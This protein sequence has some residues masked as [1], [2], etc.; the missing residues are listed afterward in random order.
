MLQQDPIQAIGMTKQLKK[1]MK[2]KAT[3]M[4]SD[5]NR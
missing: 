2:T 3:A 1:F 4:D 5:S